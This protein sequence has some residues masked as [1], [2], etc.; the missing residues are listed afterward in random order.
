MIL[1]CTKT[2]L[3]LSIKSLH[4]SYHFKKYYTIYLLK[5]NYFIPFS[6]YT[7]YCI[8]LVIILSEENVMISKI[9]TI[10]LYILILFFALDTSKKND[11]E[12]YL[13]WILIL[14][15]WSYKCYDLSI[16]ITFLYITLF[17]QIFSFAIS[18]K[19]C[20]KNMEEKKYYIMLFIISIYS[21]LSITCSY[22]YYY[23]NINKINHENIWRFNS[24]IPYISSF[25]NELLLRL[26]LFV[27]SSKYYFT[28][29]EDF[30]QQTQFIVGFLIDGIILESLLP[31]IRKFLEYNKQNK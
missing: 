13:F 27:N 1:F 16:S 29:S 25:I 15:C 4:Y 30:I 8:I 23:L 7:I 2:Y 5:I 28:I 31:I 24:Y 14:N 21:I 26:Y 12:N 10:L 9:V 6:N 18:I 17:I 20:K 22:G 11:S 3:S 19:I